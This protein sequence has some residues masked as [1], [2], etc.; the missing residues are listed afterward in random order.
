MSE[1]ADGRVTPGLVAAL[2]LGRRELVA[3]VGG[4]TAPQVMLELARQVGD[5]G[6]AARV[7]TTTWVPA[8]AV[9][10]LDHFLYDRP[11]GDRLIGAP[12]DDFDRLMRLGWVEIAGVLATEPVDHPVAAPGPDEPMMPR[13]TTHVVSVIGASA[14]DGVIEDVCHR[15]GRIASIVGCR[16]YERLTPERAAIVL[17]DERGGRRG[18][19]PM[20]RHSVV[21][22]ELGPAHEARVDRLVAALR[23]ADPAMAV[24]RMPF[25]ADTAAPERVTLTP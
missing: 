3:F 19:P 22:T 13:A 20:A 9:S 6:R 25:G 4:R 15:P 21:I 12:T 16:P 23:Q 1:S 18:V 10:G 11:E 5:A 17:L 24:V 7:G 2:G 8:A 14:L